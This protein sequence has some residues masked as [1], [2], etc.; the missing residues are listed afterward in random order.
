MS[1]ILTGLWQPDIEVG[2]GAVLQRDVR[3]Y[4]RDDV[5]N[6]YILIMAVAP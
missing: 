6:V 4:S 2:I 3:V 5:G 1:S